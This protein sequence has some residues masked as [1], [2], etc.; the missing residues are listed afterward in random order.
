MLPLAAQPP[1]HCSVIRIRSSCG[2]ARHVHRSPAREMRAE[3]RL[4]QEPVR[5]GDVQVTCCTRGPM[6]E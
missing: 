5:H 6:V 2:I 1:A 4:E 3:A